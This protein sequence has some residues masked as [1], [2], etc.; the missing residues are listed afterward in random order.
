MFILMVFA[1]GL[2]AASLMLFKEPESKKKKTK[3]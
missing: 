3:E 1:R 2:S